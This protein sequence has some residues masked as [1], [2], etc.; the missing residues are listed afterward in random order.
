MEEGLADLSRAGTLAILGWCFAISGSLGY[1]D[2]V[3]DVFNTGFLAIIFICGGLAILHPFNANLG[4]DEKQDRTLVNG[5]MVGGIV[6]DRHG[7]CALLTLGLAA[8][9]GADCS[10]LCHLV[11]LLC[12][13]LQAGQ[14]RCLSSG[15][16][17]T[18]AAERR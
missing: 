16:N 17:R 6:H 18:S 11:L 13:V 5:V 4:P 10:G 12:L 2:I 1:A 7:N 15:R 9:H 14:E 3:K 8:G